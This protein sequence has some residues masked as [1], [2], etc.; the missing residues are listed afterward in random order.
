MAS[1]KLYGATPHTQPEVVKF[2][3]QER[4]EAIPVNFRRRTVGT[5]AAFDGAPPIVAHHIE[6]FGYRHAKG[7]LRALGRALGFLDLIH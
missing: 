5:R 1:S 6:R 3:V 4:D 2:I 7:K